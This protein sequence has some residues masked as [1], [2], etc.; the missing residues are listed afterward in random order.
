M[1]NGWE[2]H[3]E[4]EKIGKFLTK[5]SQR[6]IAGEICFDIDV[7]RSINFPFLDDFEK[8]GWMKLLNVQRQIY[9]SMVR[10][11][12]YNTE[13]YDDE[14]QKEKA[15]KGIA[16]VRHSHFFHPSKGSSTWLMLA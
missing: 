10:L 15:K 7:L 4:P 13:L 14:I 12:Y 9:P 8:W 11:F 16:M 5:Y 1:C 6:P 2:A 3:I